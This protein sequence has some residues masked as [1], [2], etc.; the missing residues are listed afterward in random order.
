M[1][2]YMKILIVV[3]LMF[4]AYLLTAQQYKVKW[5]S[6]SYRVSIINDTMKKVINT[7]TWCD[8][9]ESK[10]ILKAG[11]D[12]WVAYKVNQTNTH[13]AIG[14]QSGAYGFCW[15]TIGHGLYL[16]IDGKLIKV[17]GSQET[18]LTTYTTG[19]SIKVGRIGTKIFYYKNNI[20]LDSTTVNNNVDLYIDAMIWSYQGAFENVVSSFD[21]LSVTSTTPNSRKGEGTV[22][23]AA[24]SSAGTL[25]WYSEP[26]GGV[27]LGS[28]TSFTTPY[29]DTTTTFYVCATS[30]NGYS[31]PRVAVTATIN[32]VIKIE[33]TNIVGSTLSND[34]LTRGIIRN[35]WCG[36]G[37]S[38]N[39]LKAGEDGWVA[40]K[41]NQTDKQRIL[42]FQ[43]LGTGV[44]WGSVGW[45][46]YL[47]NNS[48]LRKVVGT[49]ENV[50]L[51]TYISGD[52]IKIERKGNKIYYYKNNIKLDSTEQ[53]E[54]AWGDFFVDAIMYVSNASFENVI[55][56][57][58]KLSITST[59]SVSRCGEGSVTLGATS[60]G[61]TINWYSV[62][63]GGVSLGTGTTFVTPSLTSTTT[64]YVDVTSSHGYTTSPRVPVTAIIAPGAT[65]DAGQ[66][67]YTCYGN[68]AVLTASGGGAYLW[69][70]GEQTGTI[71][72]YPISTTNY[73]V[74]ISNAYKCISTDDVTVFVDNEPMKFTLS[75]E[76]LKCTYGNS[77][78]ITLDGSEIGINYQLYFDSYVAGSPIAGTGGKLVFHSIAPAT[79][80][81]KAIDP[82]TGC[83][84]MMIG[85][86]IHNW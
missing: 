44:C 28:G 15:S 51:S 1:N 53:G 46:L 54:T 21:V 83:E 12:G 3:F 31:T 63:T 25:N 19:D 39:I 38:K 82:I 84:T 64:Y 68:S 45:G 27:L 77:V 47:N 7:S 16:R 48:E 60:S 4:S 18:I 67:V 52:S 58:E 35:N 34:T 76:T 69:S 86:I 62:P 50:L 6:Y 13:R 17:I 29:L 75:S 81:I 30:T 80:T 40:Y 37:E 78:M 79:Y 11:N 41:V 61:G 57:F 55:A 72:V 32:P 14:L 23:L 66:D 9:A 5:T 49:T 20:K 8:G 43:R 70:T 22:A 73:T 65:A 36:G 56:S 33:W 2:K 74:T 24:T 10:N 42:G 59:N 26:A 85:S 71:T